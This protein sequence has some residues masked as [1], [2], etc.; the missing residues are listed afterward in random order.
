MGG[1]IVADYGEDP[2]GGTE[3]ADGAPFV[4]GR[5]GNRLRACEPV[6]SNLIHYAPMA[7]MLD[8]EEFKR[9]YQK[10][11]VEE[12][13]N[14]VREAV[15]NP[16][17]SVHLI[18]YNHADYIRQAIESVL[19]QEAEF[20][21]EIVIGDDESSD[22]TREI[23]VKYAEQ[24]PDKIRLLMHRR[25]N[26]IEL[27][28]RPTHL[29]QYWYNTFQ[30]RGE[31]IAVLSGDDYWT[32]PLKL[33]MQLKYLE[34]YDKCSYCYHPAVYRYEQPDNQA[35]GSGPDCKVVS[36]PDELALPSSIMMENIFGRVPSEAFEVL[37]EDTL[38]KKLLEL[39]GKKKFID[40]IDPS[41]YRIHE[42]GI[43]G[44]RKL[45]EKRMEIFRSNA[46]LLNLF[47]GTE[48]EGEIRKN[49]LE[50]FRMMMK[51]D[52]WLSSKPYLGESA[53]ILWSN[54]L[55]FEA[56]KYVFRIEVGS[57]IPVS[58]KCAIKRML[59]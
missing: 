17:L 2:R 4:G 20:P 35:N 39:K 45:K 52:G 57:K 19:M 46:L 25:E 27:R 59:K 42:G 41:V 5:G 22:G 32:D 47:R 26:N 49:T 43:H 51:T 54:E 24:H 11:P 31:Y 28:G 34:E 55:L 10:V 37:H 16:L 48:K 53:S 1:S 9:R 14:R 29:F 30:A 12:Y 56:I 8:F 13:P 15:P 33:G 38:T 18:T 21:F 3:P 44:P 23:C 6:S 50:F 36:S 58:Y 7:E 40:N